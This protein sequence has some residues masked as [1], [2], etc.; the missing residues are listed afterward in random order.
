M[1]PF[2]L[3]A[4]NKGTVAVTSWAQMNW[5]LSLHNPVACVARV[6]VGRYTVR[7][8]KPREELYWFSKNEGLTTSESAAAGSQ[9]TTCK[10]EKSLAYT[11]LYAARIAASPCD[12]Y[13]ALT[14]S[15]KQSTIAMS[16]QHLSD[17]VR[18]SIRPSIRPSS[19]REF[20]TAGGCAR[21]TTFFGRCL[22]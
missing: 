5:L 14:T 22:A 3:R 9:P 18:P 2:F 15:D 13:E 16:S 7:A 21:R 12:S 1:V 20:K 19:R 4:R 11:T 8:S 6:L 10:S 17:V